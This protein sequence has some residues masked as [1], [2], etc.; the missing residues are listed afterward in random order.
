M[1]AWVAPVGAALTVAPDDP[2]ATTLNAAAVTAIQR[3]AGLRGIR[4][5]PC[6]GPGVQFSEPTPR[7]GLHGALA[8]H[9]V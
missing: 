7:R 1:G 2:A 6:G 4:D 8:G 3:R 5:L 9:E